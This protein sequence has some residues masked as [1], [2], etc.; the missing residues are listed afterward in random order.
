MSFSYRHLSHAGN[1]GDVL[2][3]IC[4]VSCLVKLKECHQEG[5]VLLDTHAGIATYELDRQTTNEYKE[6][7][8][9]ILNTC[10]KHSPALVQEYANIVR[11]FNHDHGELRLCLSWIARSCR[12]SVER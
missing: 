9:K 6:G 5:I 4:L 8:E 11:S 1:H 2:K 3:H 10:H 12:C 7:I